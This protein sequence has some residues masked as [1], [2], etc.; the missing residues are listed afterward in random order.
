MLRIHSA[1][2]RTGRDFGDTLIA[3]CNCIDFLLGVLS[4]ILQ[5]AWGV[6]S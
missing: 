1:S 4:T 6:G 5:T 2:R 3:S